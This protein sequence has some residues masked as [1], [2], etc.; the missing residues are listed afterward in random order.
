MVGASL[1]VFQMLLLYITELDYFLESNLHKQRVV[2]HMF[3]VFQKVI[4]YSFSQ[5]VSPVAIR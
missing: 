1:L 4:Y 2:L 5:S 3:A